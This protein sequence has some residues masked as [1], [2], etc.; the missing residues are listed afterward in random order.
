MSRDL[1]CLSVV[2]YI[3]HWSSLACSRKAWDSSLAPFLSVAGQ[4]RCSQDYEMPRG[5]VGIKEIL[6]WANLLNLAKN[7]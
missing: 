4:L 7:N 5:W 1:T 2:W 6:T 3:A